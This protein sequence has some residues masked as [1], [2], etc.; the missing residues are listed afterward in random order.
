MK[1]SYLLHVQFFIVLLCVAFFVSCKNNTLPTAFYIDRSNV[2][3]TDKKC[4]MIVDGGVKIINNDDITSVSFCGYCMSDEGMRACDSIMKYNNNKRGRDGFINYVVKEIKLRSKKF[5][6]VPDNE[7]I[8]TLFV[9]NENSEWV[10]EIIGLG[11]IR[12]GLL[13]TRSEILSA[14]KE[15]MELDKEDFVIRLKRWVLKGVTGYS[16]SIENKLDYDF[17]IQCK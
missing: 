5:K 1:K 3:H 11:K 9:S 6:E 17:K 15:L 13:H 8:D 4:K 2:I 16:S 12:F 10:Y 7:L 14:K